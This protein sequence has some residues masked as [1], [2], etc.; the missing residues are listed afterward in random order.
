MNHLWSFCSSDGEGLFLLLLWF[1]GVL[2][3]VVRLTCLQQ[4]ISLSYF[5]SYSLCIRPDVVHSFG[6][7]KSIHK[8]NFHASDR[9][10]S[11]FYFYS[12][13]INWREFMR[14]YNCS[15]FIVNLVDIQVKTIW[16]KHIL[17]C[18]LKTFNF[19][20]IFLFNMSCA[21]L[22]SMTVHTS[23]NCDEWT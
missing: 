8:I 23:N 15:K 22:M 4:F 13:F 11:F 16:R 6:I 19:I 17:N 18:S 21:P 2:K 5:L 14:S 10:F 3:M 7:K 1:L 9:N 12:N 20:S